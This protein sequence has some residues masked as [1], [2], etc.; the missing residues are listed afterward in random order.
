MKLSIYTVFD[1]KATEFCPPWVAKTDAV[2]LRMFN[3][4]AQGEHIVYFEDLSLWRVGAFDTDSGQ[5]VDT[6]RYE[7]QNEQ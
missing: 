5:I 2:A 7:V 3:Q 4:S 6:E 1:N